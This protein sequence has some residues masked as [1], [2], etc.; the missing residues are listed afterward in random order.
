MKKLIM[1]EEDMVYRNK[2]DLIKKKSKRNGN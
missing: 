1:K 2:R